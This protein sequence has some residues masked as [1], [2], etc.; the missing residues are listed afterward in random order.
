M[1][2]VF[3]VYSFSSRMSY[4]I[5]SVYSVCSRLSLSPSLSFLQY[6]IHKQYR[7]SFFAASR[8]EMTIFCKRDVKE[9][10]CI[11]TCHISAYAISLKHMR[12]SEEDRNRINLSGNPNDH[13]TET[14]RV[15]FQLCIYFL[16][17]HFPFLLKQSTYTRKARL[18][19]QLIDV[20]YPGSRI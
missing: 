14:S 9:V 18:L 16:A 1:H 4:S 7:P 17:I 15:R 3:S 13:C 12:H 8:W 20:C 2:S 10:G 6:T 5:H 19:F 11:T